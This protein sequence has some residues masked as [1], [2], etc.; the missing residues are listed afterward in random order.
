[1]PENFELL[2]LDR[3]VTREP[4]AGRAGPLT[5]PVNL[6]C[7]PRLAQSPVGG[8]A[9]LQFAALLLWF[10]SLLLCTSILKTL[11][12]MNARN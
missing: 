5:E 10:D 4:R 7:P 2:N 11:K 8:P 6:N 3:A 12:K 9:S 1:M